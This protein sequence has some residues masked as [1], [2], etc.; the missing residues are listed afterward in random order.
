MS[1]LTFAIS[2]IF[3]VS[4]ALGDATIPTAD[5]KGALLLRFESAP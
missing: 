4:V 5:K 1:R 2:A 3:L